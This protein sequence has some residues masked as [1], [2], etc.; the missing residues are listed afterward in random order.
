MF[1]G[2]LAVHVYLPDVAKDV[3]IQPYGFQVSDLMQNL[4]FRE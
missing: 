3:A 2:T 4:I 1:I